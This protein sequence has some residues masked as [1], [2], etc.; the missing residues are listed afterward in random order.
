MK[1]YYGSFPPSH[2]MAG[3]YL[4]GTSSPSRFALSIDFKTEMGERER[5][6][7]GIRRG[8]RKETAKVR[9]G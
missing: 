1:L 3:E 8:K 4:Q 7:V 2:S 9:A 5:E 6:K